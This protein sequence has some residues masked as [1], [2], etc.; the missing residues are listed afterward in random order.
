[1]PYAGAGM[2]TSVCYPTGGHTDF[3]FEPNSYIT[4]EPVTLVTDLTSLYKVN[5]TDSLVT[6]F[7]QAFEITSDMVMTAGTTQSAYNPSQIGK[8]I[9]LASTQITPPGPA[10][11]YSVQ[12]R[13]HDT[14]QADYSNDIAVG[15]EQIIELKA[16]HYLLL[17]EIDTDYITD[18]DNGTLAPTVTLASSL[19]VQ[20][21]Y[22]PGMERVGPGFRLKQ[23]TK[24]FGQGVKEVRTYKYQDSTETHSSGILGNV[25]HYKGY[26]ATENAETFGDRCNYTTFSNISTYPLINSASSYI[27]YSIVTEYYNTLQVSGKKVYTYTNF[28][29]FNDINNTTAFPYPPASPQDWKRGLPLTEEVYRH[30]AT[31][32]SSPNFELQERTV[33]TYSVLPNSLAVATS[34][35]VGKGVQY[36]GGEAT[37][38]GLFLGLTESLYP[39]QSDS[40]QLQTKSTTLYTQ[41]K[42][43]TTAE[44][45]AYTPAYF[46]LSLLNT[47]TS[48]GS[49]L[50]RHFYYPT[51]YLAN[52]TVSP[53]LD[54]LLTANIVNLPVE[55]T[56]SRT[57]PTAQYFIAGTLHAYTWWTGL[58]N[59]PHYYEQ[60]QYSLNTARADITQQYDFL[61]VPAHYEEQ[62]RVLG[63]NSR[64][65]P[66]A[67]RRLTK[68]KVAY[69]WGYDDRYPI[70]SCK[71]ALSTEF[72]Y[73]GFEEN[74]TAQT[75]AAHS[76]AR[77]MVGTYTVNWTTP[78]TRTYLLSYWYR[79][80]GQWH[81]LE[82][83]YTG[84][85]LTL[86]GGD[87]YDDVRIYPSDAQL[88]T[89]T[90]NPLV[91]MTSQTDPAGRTTTY[92]YDG[93]GRLLR[94]RDEQ[95]RILSQQQYHYAGH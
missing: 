60:K 49:L 4:N 59:L 19:A 36:I 56:T 70:G 33:Y 21:T 93:L 26:L 80:A 87:A 61:H 13:I 86:T 75:G 32:G 27:G 43:F 31:S 66:T 91:G 30:L 15:G 79:Q 5:R 84:S 74:S 52:R 9:I 67:Y 46:Q 69:Q 85:S 25:P 44:T 17:G 24:Y 23:L 41:S 6:R 16:G 50:S 68:E 39:I 58:D 94:T 34:I 11:G 55:E 89:F 81:Y 40:Y 82:Q 78:N 12:L 63:V 57:T 53:L 62:I 54:G 1:M 20:V 8:A 28:D 47:T 64:S 77:F 18:P 35:K 83:V 3:S 51:D 42:G 76:G 37:S 2:L 14:S 90:Y 38:Q 48:D 73:E 72:F 22:L 7:A 29:K 10:N 65:Q 95:G 88:T 71:N 45:H 92:E